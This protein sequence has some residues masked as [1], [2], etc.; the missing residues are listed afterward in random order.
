MATQ[1]TSLVGREISRFLLLERIGQGGMGVVYRARDVQLDRFVAL[2][3]IPRT[4]HPDEERKRR[5]L[6]EERAASAVN[7]PNNVHI[8]EIGEEDGTDF[9]AMEFV[10]GQRLDELIPGK[11]LPISE[12]LSY[13]VQIA[14]ALAKAH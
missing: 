7:H 1:E 4:A 5:F 10:A 11:G 8:Y 14:D 9:I 6:H 2:K 3:I 12:V 13:S